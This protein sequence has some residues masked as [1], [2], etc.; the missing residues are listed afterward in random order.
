VRALHKPASAARLL[1]MRA[2]EAMALALM[3]RD[4]SQR[5]EA[6][7]ALAHAALRCSS[8]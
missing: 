5:C 7:E 1:S 6:V 2:G 4:A 8:A 3:L